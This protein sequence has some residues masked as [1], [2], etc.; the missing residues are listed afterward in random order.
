[1]HRLGNADLLDDPRRDRACATFEDAI[2]GSINAIIAKLADRNLDRARIDRYAQAFGFGRALPFDAP[3]QASAAEVP[4][5]RLEFARTAAGFWH[6]HMSPLHG[7]L[8]AAT[9]A[10]GG[11][12]LRASMIAR[13]VDAKNQ[14]LSTFAASAYQKVIER[15]TA[16]TLGHMMLATVAHGTSRSAFLDPRGR[17]YLPGI[18]VAGKTGSLSDENPFRAYSW[19]V[20]FAPQDAPKIAL[21]ALVINTP[22]WRI[23]SS[24]VA[25]EA[26]RYYLVERNK[27]KARA[28][29]KPGAAAPPPPPPAAP[30]AADPNASAPQE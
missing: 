25:R 12:M 17:S 10:N 30:A 5:D 7:A 19:W 11:V 13:V 29:A 2:G 21:A 4:E 23:K 8:I 28:A 15:A 24:F 22:T 27:P 18:S 1:M 16:E 20:G 6:M 26:L 9:I 3:T 14:V